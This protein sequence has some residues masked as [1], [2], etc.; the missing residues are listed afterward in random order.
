MRT[1]LIVI[2]LFVGAAILPAILAASLYTQARHDPC[3]WS[4]DYCS[5]LDNALF[6]GAVLRGC[7]I[8]LIGQGIAIA[9]LVLWQWR[10]RESID[11]PSVLG[12]VAFFAVV[13]LI[14]WGLSQAALDAYSQ[15]YYSVPAG[16]AHDAKVAL[17]FRDRLDKAL[18]SFLGFGV[19]FVLITVTSAVLGG[20]NAWKF[21]DVEELDHE[22]A[23]HEAHRRHEHPEITH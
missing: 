12:G 9:A 18:S 13:S 19:V 4:D 23:V 5:P 16:A 8:S 7:A 10:S 11:W 6:V 2:G 22:I 20:I 3:L 17:D 1:R 15:L 14:A 21:V